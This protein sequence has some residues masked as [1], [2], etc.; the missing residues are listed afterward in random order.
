[1]KKLTL[2]LF[3]CVAL[4][5]AAHAA[6]APLYGS[7]LEY[8][9]ITYG[10]GTNPHF[11]DVIHPSEVIITIKRMT[12]QVNTIGE[13]DYE[14]VTER[15]LANGEA[16]LQTKTYIAKVNVARNPGIGRNLITLVSITPSSQ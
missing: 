7:V 16:D 6:V 5:Q 9:A 12:K 1:M 2:I 4:S 11:Q 15:P 3:T 8:E 13:V 14:I 10:I